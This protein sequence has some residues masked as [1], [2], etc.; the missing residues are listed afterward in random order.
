MG[1]TNCPETPRQR[2]IGMMYLVL[3]A[4]LALNVSK[5]ILNAFSI[6]DETLGKSTEITERTINSDDSFLQKQEALLGKA[7]VETAVVKVAEIKKLSDKMVKDIEALRDSLLIIVDGGATVVSKDAD[8]NEV[9]KPKT[10]NDIKSKDNISG[11]TNFLINKGKAL[12]LRKQLEEFRTNLL[13]QSNEGTR[14]YLNSTIGIDVNEKFTNKDGLEETWE[15]HYFEGTIMA[16]SV[17]LLNKLIGEVRNAESILIK[18]AI[19]GINADDFKFS[20]V[21][22]RAIPKSQMVFAGEPYEADIIVAAYDENQNPEVFYKMGVDTLTSVEGATKLEGEGGIARLKIPTSGSGDNK[23]AGIIRIKGPD[24]TPR[25]Y[26]FSDKYTVL[27][28]SATVAAEK[29]N[30]FYAGIENP[31]SVNAPCSPDKISVT[32]TGGGSIT[33]T[34]AGTY[35]VTVPASLRG[36]T[37]TVNVSAD[38][39]AGPKQ[40]GSTVFRV[41]TVPDPEVSVGGNIRGGKINKNQIS[42]GNGFVAAKMDESFA[43]DLKW[44]VN[45]FRVTFVTKGIED[46][47]IPVQGNKFTNNILDKIKKSPRGTA[48]YITDIKASSPA[49][50]RTLKD[51][52]LRL[53]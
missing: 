43:Y 34:G 5:D 13:K 2:M 25:D 11:P 22:G 1:A 38:L 14:E 39:G 15:A 19:A 51:I 20:K 7:K 41:R 53:N 33:K 10:V 36:K 23:F 48:V 3:T 9:E 28:P 18:D 24:G 47:P 35:N 16:A 6:V 17:T 44:S 32:I 46:T 40:M 27:P 50:T 31:V 49:G 8:G 45:S 30:M 26:G 52:S 4:M 21:A 12:E 29:M 37:V 42:A